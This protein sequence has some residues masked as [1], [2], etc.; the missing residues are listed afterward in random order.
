MINKNKDI[1]YIGNQLIREGYKHTYQRYLIIKVIFENDML[2]NVNEIYSKV[3]NENIGVSTIYRNIII[4]EEAGILKRINIANTNYY[5]LEKIGNNKFH[6]HAECIKCNKII[7]ISEGE[8][9]EISNVLIKELNKKQK[10]TVIS[11][12]VVLSGICEEC[13]L[14][15]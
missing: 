11:T 1:E 7:D 15:L 10:I 8:I 9:S 12:S 3:K 4:L 6:I 2:M 5:T 14:K 13:K